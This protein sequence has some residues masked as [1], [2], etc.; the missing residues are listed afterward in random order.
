MSVFVIIIDCHDD[1]EDKDDDT[2]KNIINQILKRISI[3]Q[4]VILQSRF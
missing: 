2:H 4:I 3:I 1:D